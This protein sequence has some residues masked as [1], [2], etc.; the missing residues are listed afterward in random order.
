[1][2]FLHMHSRRALLY[3]PGDDWKKIT[4]ALTLGVDCICMDMEDGVALKQK[5]KAR[6]TVSKAL[7][8]LDF[9]TTEKLARINAIG[10]G[11]EQD[12]IQAVLPYFPD[13][14]V[15]PKVESYEQIQWGSE[16]I[17]SAEL[18]NGCSSSSIRILVGVETAR[19]ILSLKEIASHPRLDGIIFGGEDFAASIG[20]ART[21]S[22]IEL[23][24]A[25]QAVVTACAAYGLQAIDIVTIDFKDI[26][27]VRREA[28]FGALLG[29]S[30]K[31]VVHPNQ[32][33]PVQA[34][35]TPSDE[36][37]AYAKS[38]VE[39]FESH[40]QEGRGAFALDGKMIDMPLLKNAQKVLERAKAA[41]KT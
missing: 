16:I 14:I 25:R 36:S 22:S 41:G 40:Q 11:L 29:F 17:Q 12:D 24:Y 19:G 7:S 35:F 9:G 4:K 34:A 21:D 8:E 33:A 20:A 3:T 26:E 13:G 30:G 10:S 1:M 18:G 23:L 31:Q 2:E 5:T 27:R 15:I 6:T 38:L 37:I 28:E 39:A 32:V